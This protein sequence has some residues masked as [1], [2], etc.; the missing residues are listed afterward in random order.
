MKNKLMNWI[1]DWRFEIFV[2][3][4]MFAI[5]FIGIRIGATMADYRNAD[6]HVNVATVAGWCGDFD[7]GDV[8][9]VGATRYAYNNN[10]GVATLEDEDGNLWDVALPVAED[11]F[12]LVWIGDNRTPNDISDDVVVKVWNEVHN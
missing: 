3:V 6:T 2:V 1:D 8:R 11:D 10:T 12:L 4:G 9:M 5:F 7:D